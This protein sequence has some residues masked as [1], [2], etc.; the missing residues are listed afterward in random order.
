MTG[1]GFLAVDDDQQQVDEHRE[2]RGVARVM[3]PQWAKMP[4]STIGMVGLQIVWSVEMSNAPA[5]LLTLGMSRSAMSVVFLAGPL[6]GLIVQPI[7]GAMADASTSRFGRRRPYIMG[8]ALLCGVAMLLL[9]FTRQFAGVFTSIPSTANDGLTIALAVLAIYC[10]DFSVNAVQAADRAILVD[11]WPREEQ[12]RGNAW[13]ARM[14]GV[15]SIA[16][17]FVGN[18]DLTRAF[19]LFGSTQIEILSV[20]SALTLIGF[21]AATSFAVK[22]RVLLAAPS[23]KGRKKPSAIRTIWKDVWSLPRTIRQI[24]LIQF[25]VWI[26]WFPILFYYSV[27]V[28]DIYKRT[29]A[30]PLSASWTQQMVEDE[31]TRLGSRALFYNSIVSF[32]ATVLLPFCILDEEKERA[33]KAAGRGWRK[34]TL[35]ELWTVSQA[36]FVF[37]MLATWWTTGVFGAQMIMAVLGLC[38]AVAQWAP[39]SLLGQ[40]ILSE[41]DG[42]RTDA[43]IALDEYEALNAEDR[44]NGDRAMHRKSFES[45][46][47]DASD[48]D[49]VEQPRTPLG[50]NPAARLSHASI[51]ISSPHPPRKPSRGGG[52]G[53]KGGSILGIHNIFVVIPQF[54]VSGFSSLVF[55]IFEP[56]RTT[57]P[58]PGLADVPL[59]NA[60]IAD[61]GLERWR[62]AEAEMEVSGG[63][64]ALGF[65]FRFGGFSAIVAC[66][67]CWKL[68][69]DLRSRNR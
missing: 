69:K 57:T 42:P 10:I 58:H 20:L 53:D 22:E 45:T 9:G 56:S 28:G 64:D 3:G 18:V 67:L 52:I 16:G 39:F 63:G 61:D 35:A 2:W 14:G 4:L 13:A 29:A 65:I 34:P 37:C 8:G 5:Y 38:S 49:D 25:F 32:G 41:S 66:W 62:R 59:L 7:V 54:L 23:A 36:V 6:S 33:E 27:Y 30:P 40:A 46:P 44:E 55:A 48:L 50:S 19:P 43:D 47:S 21:H 24:C 15:G 11:V 12:E 31:A 17:F 51:D 68:A 1:G 26:A 60:T